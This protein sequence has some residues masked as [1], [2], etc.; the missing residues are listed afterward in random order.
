[1]NSPW[2]PTDDELLELVARSA[3]P[4]PPWVAARARAAWD[5]RDADRSLAELLDDSA[6]MGTTRAAQ[7]AQR[8]VAYALHAV[9]LE[10]TVEVRGSRCSIGIVTVPSHPLAVSVSN[11]PFNGEATTVAL[12]LDDN[13]TASFDVSPD[14][15]ISLRTDI[16]GTRFITPWLTL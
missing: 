4:M 7:T 2:V 6:L 12:T 11:M 9:T 16:E 10:L 5:W 1:M 15:R 14:A 13:G 8:T 3:G